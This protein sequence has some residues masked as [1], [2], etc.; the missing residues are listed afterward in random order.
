LGGMKTLV[1]LDIDGTLLDAQGEGKS[2]FYEVLEQLFPGVEFPAIDMAGRTDLG[3]WEQ[4][5]AH[6]KPQSTAPTF[7][8]F[9]QEYGAILE[10]RLSSNPPREIPGALRF[11]QSLD[12]HPD[13]IPCLVT[14][15]F[16]DGARHKLKALGCWSV[17]ENAD[18]RGTWGDQVLT[19]KVLA[20]QLLEKWWEE[21]PGP[22]HAVF[23]GDTMADLE[24]AQH[25]GI[26]C[27]IV[28]G[29][30]P[31]ADFMAAGAVAS[32]QDLQEISGDLA[33]LIDLAQL[34]EQ[35]P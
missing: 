3:I 10:K 5:L 30:R 13:L 31:S 9:A 22:V 12:G 33:G 7:E 35:L 27:I 34:I 15:N 11:L 19:K 18:V 32:W 25:A 4:L 23:L 20:R 24:C 26:P 6:I 28:N 14:G 1:L 8:T 16:R 2:G 17:F 29:N 21:N